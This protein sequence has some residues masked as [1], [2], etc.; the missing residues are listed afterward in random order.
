[1][2]NPPKYDKCEDMANM[3][4]LNDPSV[5]F[6]LKIRYVNKLIYV[7]ETPCVPCVFEQ[8]ISY[9]YSHQTGRPI[10]DSSAL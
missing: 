5:L 10:Q 1:M 6:N 3:T 8:S 9:Q 2:V 4:Y 7:R